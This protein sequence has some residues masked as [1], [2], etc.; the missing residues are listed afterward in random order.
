[1]VGFGVCIFSHF[2]MLYQEKIWQPCSK[3]WWPGQSILE[4]IVGSL[5]KLFSQWHSSSVSF[6]LCWLLFSVM[7]HMYIPR[8]KHTLH[9]Y[10]VWRANLRLS[11]WRWLLLLLLFEW[12]AWRLWSDWSNPAGR[13]LGSTFFR[14]ATFQRQVYLFPNDV[15]AN[16]S[17]AESTYCRT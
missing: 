11:F 9:T 13:R 14:I 8:V 2:G 6:F 17:V 12:Q 10:F 5:C 15:L 3:R 16:K 1:L 4:L 7:S